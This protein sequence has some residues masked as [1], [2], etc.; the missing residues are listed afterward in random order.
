[1]TTAEIRSHFLEYFRARGHAVLPS[2]SLVPA[3][4]PTLLFTNAGMVQFK[5]VF[6]G[7]SD[8]GVSRAATSQK[9]VRAGGKHND[10]EEVGRT[11]RHL[12]FF[13]MLGNFSFGDY[14]KKDAIAFAWELMT[15]VYGL[16]PD[17][18]FAT[19]HHTDDEAAE[20]WRA[21]VGLPASRIF[22]LGDEDN[23]WQ[24]AD[25]GPCG[26]CSEL[27][28][29]LRPDRSKA[30]TQAEFVKLNEAGT[31]VELWNLVFMQFDRDAA[32]VL[33]PLPA[34]CVDTGAGLERLAAVLQGKESV[35]HTDVFAP[36]LARVAD[37]IGQ[38]YDAASEEAVSFHVLA[39]HARAV[40][41]LLSDGVFPSSE[42]RGYVL[43]RILRRAVRHAWLLG[44]REP[45]LVGV[46]DAVVDTMGGTYPELHAQRSHLLQATRAEEERFLATIE[47]GMA[48]FDQLAAGKGG[49]IPG[50]E[51]FKLYD[52]FGFP[53]DLTEL[54]A[55]ERGYRVDL[56]GFERAL[57]Q[58]RTRSR[59][60]RAASQIGL[61]DLEDGGAWSVLAD[62]AQSFV[63]YDTL[64]VSTEV[65]A[66]R[67]ADVSTGEEG[68]AGLV[69]RE[70]PFYLESGGQVSDVGEVRSEGWTLEVT[71]VASDGGRTAVFGPV[72]G[73]LPKQPAAPLRVEAEVASA[74][75]N[76]TVRNHTA[77]HLLHASLRSVL[78]RHV[79]QRGSLVA[80]DRLRF[81]FAHKAPMTAEE[82]KRVEDLV[83]EGIWANHPVRI[84]QRSY[85]EAVAA[86]AMA[87]FGE[88]YGDVV[89]VVQVPGVS[90]ELCGG[91]HAR[92]TGE[93]GLFRIVSE[94]G[95]ASG[96]RRLEAL[97]G[98]GAFHHL[99]AK[100]EALVEAAAVLRTT[101][102]NLTHRAEQML[103]ERAQLEALL[104][105]LRT[106]GG[107]GEIDVASE[108]LQLSGGATARYR[109]LRLRAR[110]ADDARKW[111]D[112]FLSGGEPGVVV[113]A[114][115][116]PGDKQALFA[117]V[118]DDLIRRGV[119]ADALVRDV[120]AIVGGKGGG[121]PHMAQAGVE[122]PS[123]V[124]EA[125]S[126]GVVRVRELLA[127][128][129]A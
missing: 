80:P 47:G 86:G 69:L 115:E 76:D 128:G 127:A 95:V 104:D 9:C 87:L 83:N 120:A 75:R 36:M 13:E 96:V 82:K 99:T 14:F 49:T 28:Y 24:M 17:R 41:F 22:R 101:P 62:G 116:M 57:D 92:S 60:D 72:R 20:L 42:G 109:G 121:R 113:L 77:T 4:D 65:L 2:S 58:Q 74:F 102:A 97:T 100:E 35:F 54:M 38:K 46:V 112:A 10:L 39:D 30:P 107:A 125:L 89:R 90:L 84:D 56:A 61:G 23:F 73:A 63:G 29:D 40:A 124:D 8:I 1:M 94:S 37:V 98:R 26:P 118:T 123:R 105:E 21:E 51:A 126:A 5:R 33:A 32:G 16:D 103:E 108:T 25:V 48:R 78:G 11:A 122:D 110:G 81:D 117:F 45:T 7:E 71:R 64:S 68:D 85:P 50:E 52:T 67:A 27:H 111:G 70:N 106:G 43:R 59:A 6:L 91:T 34:P 66:Y 55:A 3:D 114:A 18:F 15:E 129:A 93:I 119:R 12:T 53:I 79:V 44:R 19:V 88:K 31:I